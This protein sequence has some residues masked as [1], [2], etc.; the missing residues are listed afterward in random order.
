MIRNPLDGSR[1][2][3]TPLSYGRTAKGRTKKSEISPRSPRAGLGS[4]ARR[5]TAPP[6]HAPNAGECRYVRMALPR[7]A[8][9]LPM[10]AETNTSHTDKTLWKNL[11][12]APMLLQGFGG[13]TRE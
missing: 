10:P 9:T 1:G 5:M 7:P 4:G 8:E 2:H 3:L 6:G 13:Y 12:G 11:T